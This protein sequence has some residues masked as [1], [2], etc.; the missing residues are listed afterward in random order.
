MSGPGARQTRSDRG[1]EVTAGGSDS[2]HATGLRGGRAIHRGSLQCPTRSAG[3]DARRQRSQQADHEPR[4]ARHRERNGTNRE[5]RQGDGGNARATH[6]IRRVP[7]HRRPE[8][9]S[10]EKREQQSRTAAA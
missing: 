9:R 4:A 7:A 2:G 8:Q 6:S 5:R 1:A 3:T 10:E